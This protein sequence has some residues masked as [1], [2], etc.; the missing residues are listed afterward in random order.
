MC[1]LLGY[2]GEPVLVYDMLYRFKN[3]LVGQS[4]H[5]CESEFVVNGDGFGLGWY[6]L[7]LGPE[8][9]VFASVQPA[10][11]NSNLRYLTQKLKVKSFIAHIRAATMGVV[12]Q[13]NCHPFHFDRWLFA[14]NGNI[15]NFKQLRRLWQST[16]DEV[17]YEYI[18]GQ[19][20]SQNMFAM[21]LQKLLSHKPREL[22]TL[23]DY[24]DAMREMLRQ[25][26]WLEHKTQKCFSVHINCVITDGTQ[27][28]GMRYTNQSFSPAPSLYWSEGQIQVGAD[29]DEAFV[30]PNVEKR[31]VLI[32]SEK[33]DRQSHWHEVPE[34]HFVLIDQ[35][36]QVQCE[37]IGA[38][39]LWA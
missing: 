11:N 29:Q 28:F 39:F 19:T 9:G 7:D 20:D 6:D 13:S 10:W 33:M 30:N 21:W 3:S 26:K 35:N 2:V 16:L 27:M 38:E 36:L 8:P 24:A 4:K 15:E 22:L 14:H 18:N 12:S 31:C 23:H 5:A 37:S 32:A 34:N 1:R 25:L 17:Y